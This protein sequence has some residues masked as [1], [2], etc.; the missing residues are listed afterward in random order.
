MYRNM[1][2]EILNINSIEI[3]S[4][5]NNVE[6]LTREITKDIL[7]YITNITEIKQYKFD[8]MSKLYYF[9]IEY[10]NNVIRKIR[11]EKSGLFV[12]G[13]IFKYNSIEKAKK[14]RE[15]IIN[16]LEKYK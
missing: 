8:S 3:N 6:I 9:E 15:K 10:E 12:L 13:N 5:K 4:H 16:F 1:F 2:E 7:K 11:N 14:E